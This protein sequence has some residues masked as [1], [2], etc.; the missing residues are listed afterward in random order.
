MFFFVKIQKHIRLQPEELGKN[1]I[2]K[3]RDKID[4]TMVGTCSAV[5]GYII[6]IVT[7]KDKDVNIQDGRIQDTTGEV[8][9]RVSF[10]ALVFKPF[11]DEVLDGVVVEVTNNGIIIRSGPLESF[12]SA[13]R[14]AESESGEFFHDSSTNQ[15]VSRR[16][17]NLRIRTDSE[18]RYKVFQI[19]YD[20]GKY[21]SIASISGDYLG[22]IQSQGV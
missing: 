20:Q 21:D 3:I 8:I 10:T 16:D 12:I 19:K 6:H 1:L 14:V 2:T 4:S 18:I 11:V 15:F 5:H 17:P 9:F 13:A 7:F 22:P